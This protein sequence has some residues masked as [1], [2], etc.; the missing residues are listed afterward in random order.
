MAR[1]ECVSAPIEMTSTP[2]LL[3]SRMRSSETPPEASIDRLGRA[4][5]DALDG[6]GHLAN[7]EVVEQD[8]LGARLE[9]LVELRE[10]VDLDADA[11]HVRR[12]R[13][14][15]AH[16]LAHRAHERDVVV[17]DE[18]PRREVR[19]VVRAAARAHGVLLERARARR[20]LA[21]VGDAH[22]RALRG[23]DEAPA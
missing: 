4:L 8:D 7:L 14:R 17:L 19:A 5:A 6:L 9:R 15:A 22:L 13:A 16:G 23:R 2:V 21:R 12:R 3:M 10:V 11:Q 1:A 20:R 18:D